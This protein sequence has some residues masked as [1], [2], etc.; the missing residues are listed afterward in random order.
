M[1]DPQFLAELTDKIDR[2][3]TMFSEQE[4]ERLRSISK[5]LPGLLTTYRQGGQRDEHF[6]RG[7]PGHPDNEMGM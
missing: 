7:D 3:K 5:Y 1:D 6:R 2:L 4:V